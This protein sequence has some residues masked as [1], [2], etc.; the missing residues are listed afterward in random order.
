[1]SFIIGMIII[2]VNN[3]Y[4]IIELKA[5]L[6]AKPASGITAKHPVGFHPHTDSGRKL[7]CLPRLQQDIYR[8]EKIITR[9][10]CRSSDRNL[11]VIIH[12]LY[13]LLIRHSKAIFKSFFKLLET[14]FFKH[15]NPLCHIIFSSFNPLSKKGLPALFINIISQ[16]AIS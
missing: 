12:R 1:M 10:T 16:S 14:H 8:R 9:R 5:V 7:H 15:C 6:E 13:L 4:R 3:P 11:Q 2:T